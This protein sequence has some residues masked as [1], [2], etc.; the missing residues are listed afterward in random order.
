MGLRTLL[1]H[2]EF[3]I[4]NSEG[5]VLAW[6]GKTLHKLE[7]SP[8]EGPTL[9]IVVSLNY[10]GKPMFG[11]GTMHRLL[12]NRAAFAPLKLTVDGRRVS[13]ENRFAVREPDFSLECPIWTAPLLFA[14]YKNRRLN[15]YLPH[16]ERAKQGFV[17]DPLRSAEIFLTLDQKEPFSQESVHLNPYLRF[18][19]LNSQDE[20]NRKKIF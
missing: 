14:H 16:I 13:P 4:R 3:R 18:Q 8:K 2:G 20:R 11:A 5:K 7:S 15:E 17:T 1:F 19:N 9:S 10:K 6:D 12:Y